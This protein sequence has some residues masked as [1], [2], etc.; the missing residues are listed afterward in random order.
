M[1]TKRSVCLLVAVAL[2][3]LLV[4]SWPPVAQGQQTPQ[5]AVEQ[6]ERPKFLNPFVGNPAAIAEGR[7][8]FQRMGCEA[9]HGPSGEGH[10]YP[11]VNDDI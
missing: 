10:M 9:C 3:L 2:G 4:Q 5:K 6:T 1:R 11:A 8:L 7:M